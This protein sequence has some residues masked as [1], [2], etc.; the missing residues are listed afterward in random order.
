MKWLFKRFHISVL[1]VLLVCFSQ[2]YFSTVATKAFNTQLCYSLIGKKLLR[3]LITN[4]CQKYH[5]TQRQF[6][7]IP[8]EESG[9]FTTVWCRCD[10]TVSTPILIA[11]NF[12]TALFTKKQHNFDLCFNTVQLIEK[13]KKWRGKQCRNSEEKPKRKLGWR[14]DLVGKKMSRLL[15]KPLNE[16]GAFFFAV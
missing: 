9:T 5:P 16:G 3:T 4:C 1:T 8:A 7:S 6:K 14:T 15:G 12:I 11:S 10:K 13:K 2:K